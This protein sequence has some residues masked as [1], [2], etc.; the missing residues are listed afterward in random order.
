MC[1]YPCIV[2]YVLLP[3]HRILYASTLLDM[4][5]LPHWESNPDQSTQIDLL[6]PLSH[7]CLKFLSGAV[8]RD[9][10]G[11]SGLC[12]YYY[13]IGQYAQFTVTC[14][15]LAE[16]ESSSTSRLTL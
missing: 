4:S 14:T 8:F 7:D 15:M 1:F 16:V 13:L 2:P 6:L 5:L 12:I 9:Y 11:L 10:S 3:L